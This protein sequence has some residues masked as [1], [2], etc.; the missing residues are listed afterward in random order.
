[1]GMTGIKYLL[2]KVAEIMGKQF[3][4]IC[5]P[6]RQLRRSQNVRGRRYRDR[7]CITKVG[8]DTKIR[9]LCSPTWLDVES[10]CLW[11]EMRS[12]MRNVMQDEQKRIVVV[13]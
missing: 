4:F 1:M 9:Q 7:W 12:I 13:Y 2:Q 8:T 10:A 3:C 11:N 5:E 6:A